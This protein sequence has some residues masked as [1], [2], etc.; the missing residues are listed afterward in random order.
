M[1]KLLINLIPVFVVAGVVWFFKTSNRR[2][3]I[4]VGLT[5]LV[6]GLGHRYLGLR[7]R[8]LLFGGIIIPLFL[9]GLVL[10][11]FCNVS[12]FDRHPI[13]GIAQIP[14]G[15]MTLIAWLSTMS[16]ELG[17]ENPYYQVGCLYTGT[18]CL[19]NVLSAC[20]AWDLGA[21]S[22]EETPDLPSEELPAEATT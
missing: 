15:L 16:L 14:G 7:S 8:A 1:A 22:E 13:W 4:A 5:L 20:D 11:D 17:G 18:A 21:E 10:A 2:Q 19:L 12:P 6:P 3:R 9:L